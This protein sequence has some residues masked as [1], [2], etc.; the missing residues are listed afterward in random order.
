MGRSGYL[1]S[2][3][4]PKK[5]RPKVIVVAADEGAA[6]GCIARQITTRNGQP[7][8][9]ECAIRFLAGLRLEHR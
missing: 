7:G 4:E 5:G 8:H 1:N 6:T 9:V 3:P 2:L